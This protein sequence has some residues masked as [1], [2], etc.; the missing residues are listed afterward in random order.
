ME[1]RNKSLVYENEIAARTRG[2]R[3]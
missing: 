3:Q 2:R 1:K